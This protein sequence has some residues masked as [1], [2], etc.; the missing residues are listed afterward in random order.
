MDSMIRIYELLGIFKAEKT[1][2]GKFTYR[3]IAEA[4]RPFAEESLARAGK[5]IRNIFQILREKGAQR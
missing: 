3:I 4:N 5:F 1:K 2:R